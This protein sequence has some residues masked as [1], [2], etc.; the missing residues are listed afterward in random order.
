VPDARLDRLAPYFGSVI[1]EK[2]E[3]Q[4]HNN[5]KRFVEAILAQ[6]DP[7]VSVERLIS[8]QSA[9]KASNAW[10]E[11]QAMIKLSEVKKKNSRGSH[12]N[13]EVQLSERASG[14]TLG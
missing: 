1:H 10:L 4:D 3:V 9:L 13:D 6:E 14:E 8:S 11:L 12:G 2:Q 7:C 5:F